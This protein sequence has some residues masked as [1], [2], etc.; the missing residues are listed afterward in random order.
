MNTRAHTNSCT[1]C[2]S[3]ELLTVAM[4]MEDGAV[5]FWTCSMCEKTG[6]QRNGDSV[7]RSAALSDIPR[8]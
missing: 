8:R 3:H 7:S 4:N 1:A 5:T 2:G 6:W